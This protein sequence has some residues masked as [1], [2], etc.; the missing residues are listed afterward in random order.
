[1]NKVLFWY[2]LGLGLNLQEK[3]NDVNMK[4]CFPVMTLIALILLGLSGQVFAA[5]TEWK[6][7]L[8]AD[9]TISES[10]STEQGQHINYSTSWKMSEEAG[11]I[12]FTRAIPTWQV[13]SSEV[14]RLPV[15]ITVK[16]YFLWQDIEIISAAQ[17]NAQQGVFSSL[18]DKPVRLII[19]LPGAIGTSSADSIEDGRT[20]IWQISR[21]ADIQNKGLLLQATL[22]DGYIVSILLFVLGFAVIAGL[23]LRKIRK[24]HKLIEEEYSLENIDLENLHAEKE[25]SKD[26]KNNS[27]S[28]KE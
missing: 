28:E 19:Q 2:N 23:F 11:R 22:V 21:G 12:M 20:A 24:T 25:V 10:V 6:L 13:Y 5:D 15:Q 26:N 14:D 3:G 16:D 7:K 4:R 9:R 27:D 17:Q 8:N 1:M 18:A